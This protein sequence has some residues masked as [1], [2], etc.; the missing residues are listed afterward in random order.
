MVTNL[1][2]L[3]TAPLA[4]PLATLLAA[5]LAFYVSPAASQGNNEKKAPVFVD[6]VITEPMSQTA[7]V[8]GRLTPRRAGVVAARIRGPVGEFRVDVGD[9]VKEGDVIAKLVDNRL[10]WEQRLR[11]AEVK[12][13]EAAI[14]T[15]KAEINLR[16]QELKRLERLKKS[17]AFSQARFDDKRQDVN[18]AQGAAAEAEAALIRAMAT[19]KQAEIDVYNATVRAPYDGVVS[20]RHTEVG[21]Y[22]NV[23]DP[24]VSLI[25][26]GDL[27]IEAEAPAQYI[28]GLVPGLRVAFRLGPERMM[29]ASLRA[30]VPEEN[31]L[32]RTR[33]ARFTPIFKDGDN[34]AAGQSVT[35]LLP[36]G[37]SRDV[38]SVH[39][40]AVLNLK[41][42]TMVYVVEDGA[43]QIRPVKLGE[44]VGGR[45]EV[46][47]GVKPGDLVVIRGNER[48]RPGQKV[49]YEK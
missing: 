36:A 30:V 9:R 25:G 46:L 12:E 1:R 16:T 13:S 32:T 29:E 14:K 20:K 43:A 21:S 28:A 11:A 40:D 47:S 34:L 19:F 6:A 23:G 7:P 49:V 17:V 31:P 26:D 33:T 22:V 2:L 38:V 24:V 37:A 18:K 45:F 48:L 15:A 44:A 42:K 27:E 5:L 8:I 39:K 4:A 35:L 41:G 10:V 3:L